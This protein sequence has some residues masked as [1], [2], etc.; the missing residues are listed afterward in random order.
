MEGSQFAP[1]E[2]ATVEQAEH[3]LAYPRLSFEQ[4]I[5]CIQVFREARKWRLH[6]DAS[7]RIIK[8]GLGARRRSLT[9]TKVEAA[10]REILNGYLEEAAGLDDL[11]SCVAKAEHWI[12]RLSEAATFDP[13]T[14]EYLEGT[15]EDLNQLLL[16]VNKSTSRCL[17]P[18][19]KLLRRFARPDLAEAAATKKL[20]ANP[21]DV[22]ALTSRGAAYTDLKRLRDATRDHERAIKLDPESSHAWNSY[23]RTLQEGGHF[24]EA[25]EAAKRAVELDPSRPAS[26]RLRSAAWAMNDPQ[27]ADEAIR[28]LRSAPSSTTS[29][30]VQQFCVALAAEALLTLARYEDVETYLRAV[31]SEEIML[32]ETREIIGELTVALAEELERRQGRLDLGDGSQ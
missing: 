16:L 30:G 24:K 27:A 17:L 4:L 18:M 14:G 22:A 28:I 29:P 13:V 2:I 3:A 12:D 25:L 11:G 26:R 21:D 20:S 6:Q 19:A 7:E 32:K 8:E 31:A 5:E 10:A 9:P 1:S 23:S 15:R